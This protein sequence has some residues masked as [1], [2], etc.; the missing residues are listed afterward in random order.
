MRQQLRSGE[1]FVVFTRPGTQRCSTIRMDHNITSRAARIKEKRTQD[2]EVD[3]ETLQAGIV[4]RD[5]SFKDKGRI[6]NIKIVM[7]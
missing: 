6:G 1:R 5:S 3:I 4:R 2:A 7:W